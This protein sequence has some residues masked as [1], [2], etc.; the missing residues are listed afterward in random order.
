MESQPKEVSKSKTVY[1]GKEKSLKRD[2]DFGS[3][4]HLNLYLIVPL[5]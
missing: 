5:T 3:Q 2:L 4:F 1:A